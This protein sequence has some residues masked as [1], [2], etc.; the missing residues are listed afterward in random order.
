MGFLDGSVVISDVFHLSIQVF[1]PFLYPGFDLHFNAHCTTY[2]AI[3]PLCLSKGENMPFLVIIYI[4]EIDLF[5]PIH[6]GF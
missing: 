4:Q 3:F 2:P 5:H 1:T 6:F